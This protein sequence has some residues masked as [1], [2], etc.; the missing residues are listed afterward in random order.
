MKPA[1]V[2]HSCRAV[3]DRR[4]Y[5]GPAPRGGGPSAPRTGHPYRLE[6][7]QRRGEQGNKKTLQGQ[8]PPCPL[9]KGFFLCTPATGR[10]VCRLF[11][12]KVKSNLGSDQHAG[13]KYWSSVGASLF[14]LFSFTLSSLFP[15]FTHFTFYSFTLFY[16]T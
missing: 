15:L 16:P 1:G 10:V 13:T 8:V 14:F 9:G 3:G 7:Q 4:P 12:I 2:R 6:V 5:G 11:L